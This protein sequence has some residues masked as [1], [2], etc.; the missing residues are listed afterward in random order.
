MCQIHDG[1]INAE[2]YE[3][4]QDKMEEDPE[5][6]KNI[7]KITIA[8]LEAFDD[9]VKAVVLGET[10]KAHVK[11]ALNYEEYRFFAYSINM[12]NPIGLKYLLDLYSD[13]A[14]GTQ[15]MI[16]SLLV[17]TGLVAYNTGARPGND[18]AAYL[19]IEGQKL[20]KIVLSKIADRIGKI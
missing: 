10:L 14:I 20:C 6:L 16:G 3:K 15:P 19:T 2:E 7:T 18:G 8:Q 17:G 4:Y 1:T 5:Y 11:G 12:I 13:R 9:E